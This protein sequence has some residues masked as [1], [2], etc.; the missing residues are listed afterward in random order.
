LIG[1]V[2]VSFSDSISAE[3]GIVNAAAADGLDSLLWP[4]ADPSASVGPAETL[5]R[6][7]RRMQIVAA[8]ATIVRERGPGELTVRS[9]ADVSG[10]PSSLIVEL[11]RDTRGCVAAAFDKALAVA[12][13]RAIPSFGAARG[14][15]CRVAAGAMGLVSFCEEEPELAS[16][17]LVPSSD[18]AARRTRM[19]MTLA[20]VGR[21]ELD[22]V[23]SAPPPTDVCAAAVGVAVAESAQALG[24][25]A[26][27]RWTETRRTVLKL[28]LEPYLGPGGAHDQA[29]RLATRSVPRRPEQSRR[30]SLDVRLAS[31]VLRELAES[32]ALRH[33]PMRLAGIL[34]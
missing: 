15:L 4:V 5:A 34:A 29:K 17:L 33:G 13:E 9:I 24:E 3:A 27:P 19:I 28:V 20:R 6:R 30:P 18:T 32:E 10:V 23:T 7:L 12:A 16:V 8:T 21:A 2:G 1:G 25:P 11:F 22:R 31:E 14:P 26:G